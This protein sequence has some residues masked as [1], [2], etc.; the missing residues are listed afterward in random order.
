MLSQ[1]PLSLS[2]VDLINR[3]MVEGPMSQHHHLSM[4]M[5]SSF[6]N[7]HPILLRLIRIRNS[8][9]SSNINSSNINRNTNINSINSIIIK[10]RRNIPNNILN[11]R[12]DPP[13]LFP[14]IRTSRP[15]VPILSIKDQLK[16]SATNLKYVDASS[17][18]VL[19]Y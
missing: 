9:N 13:R 18:S 11:T 2:R 14:S 17:S 19:A 8:S 5:A 7:L 4:Q 6:L 12:K 16:L 10:R 15:P 3:R 1:F